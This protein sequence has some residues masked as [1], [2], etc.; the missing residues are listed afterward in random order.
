[1]K[2]RD[3]FMKLE[4]IAPLDKEG[5][6]FVQFLSDVTGEESIALPMNRAC[7]YDLYTL[8]EEKDFKIYNTVDKEYW[9]VEVKKCQKKK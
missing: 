9:I 6:K 7:F 2:S 8:F 1:M 3:D 4:K 5:V